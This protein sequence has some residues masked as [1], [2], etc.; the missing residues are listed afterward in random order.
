MIITISTHDEFY[1]NQLIAFL[2]SIDCNSPEHVVNVFL[3]N[4][5]D[6]MKNKLTK[7]FKRHNFES[8]KVKL[9]DKRGISFILFRIELVKECF[10]KHQEN[11]VWIDTDVLVR[12]DLTQ[13]LEIK[14]KQLK[15]LFRGNHVIEEGRFNAGIFNIGY[16]DETHKLTN[17]WYTQLQKNA[18]WGMGQLELWK[19][20]KKNPNVELIEM[21]ESYNDLG[22]S[23]N[24]DS[25]AKDS[26][27]WHCK[28][29]HFNNKKF[30]KEFQYYLKMGK[31][32]TGL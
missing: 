10:E 17:D 19:A 22:D 14:P 1:L 25:F 26:L 23:T 5:P 31:K 27:M 4:Y 32:N 8:R 15:I 3:A 18:I 7:A 30:Q 6:S 20:Y 11:A 9:I 2:T 29:N 12:S 13:F 24:N 28:R 16:S 21:P